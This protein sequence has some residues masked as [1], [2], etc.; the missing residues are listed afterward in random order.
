[1]RMNRVLLDDGSEIAEGSPSSFQ[2]AISQARFESRSV[3]V[4]L[5]TEQDLE[6]FG[7]TVLPTYRVRIEKRSGKRSSDAASWNKLGE[8][9]WELVSVVGKQAFFRRVVTNRR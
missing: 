8:Q 2:L 9:G 3:G 7:D 6:S 5:V 1:M 4:E